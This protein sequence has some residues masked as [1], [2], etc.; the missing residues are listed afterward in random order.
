[1]TYPTY[2]EALDHRQ[3]L[4]DYP[5]GQDFVDRYR[6]MSRDELF[7][8]QDAQ[9]RRLMKRGWQVPFYKRL[10]GAQ[11]IGP[12]DIKGLADTGSIAGEGPERDGMYVWEDAQYLE[13]L[14]VDSGAAVERGGTGDMVVTCL[15]K[16]DIA[17]CI[18]FNTHDITHE[19]DGRGEIAFKRIAGFRGRSD[20]M[21]KLRGINVFPHAIG[22][23]I[24]NRPDLTGEYVCHL[25]RD[26]GGRDALRVTLESHGGTNCDE[27]S[28]TLKQGLGVEVDVNLV[29][30]GATARDTQ[31][32]TRQ[33][34]LRL[35]DLRNA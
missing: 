3:M 21:V 2:F 20:N 30:P 32:D 11:G 22:S 17:P 31:I 14:D 26:D 18:R 28:E 16:D 13:L 7:A 33:K 4:A 5:V 29:D 10:W 8:I 19:L 15:Y 23:I 12:G 25:T 35:I 1:M 27:L 34:P 9:F 24:E 6:S